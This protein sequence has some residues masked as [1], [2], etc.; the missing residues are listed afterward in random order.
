MMSRFLVLHILFLDFYA[1]IASWSVPMS[2]LVQVG[3]IATLPCNWTTQRGMTRSLSVNNPH[4]QWQTPEETVFEQK[5]SIT[6]QGI[7]YEGRVEMLQDML[8][9]GDC[10]L[11]LR[12]ARFTDAGLYESFLITEHK[13]RMM[14]SFIKSVQLTVTDHKSS[15]TRLVGQD[16]SL[17]L[18]TSQASTVIFQASQ[19]KEE[20][21]KWE[22]GNA[23]GS[24]WRMEAGDRKLILP[25]LKRSDAGMYKV[26]D[27]DGLAIS[28]TLLIVQE[29]GPNETEAHGARDA[30]RDVFS[31]GIMVTVS[32]SL[33]SLLVSSSVFLHLV[34]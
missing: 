11:K 13:R 15:Q 1:M 9:E 2:V 6:F 18:Y 17:S 19:D 25:R 31:K 12:E 32:T 14:R 29:P 7:G 24:E 34:L 10:S 28:T 30:D 3:D 8:F 27:A 26:L 20:A 21:T 16:F 23:Q 5:G 33:V 22:R 4:L